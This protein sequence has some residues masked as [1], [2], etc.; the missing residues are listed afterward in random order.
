MINKN[1]GLNGCH[2]LN[3]GIILHIIQ[4]PTLLLF[5]LFITGIHPLLR[6]ELGSTP[7][8]AVENQLKDC[9]LVLDEL[10]QHLLRAQQRMK[11]Y[12]DKKRRDLHF[13]VGDWVYVKLKPY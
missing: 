6:F 12:A 13:Q 4:P 7:F 8:S 11:A 5:L 10:K 9:N 2:E 1:S 3:F